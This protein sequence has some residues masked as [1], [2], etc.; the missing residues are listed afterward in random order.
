MNRREKV[1]EMEGVFKE[2]CKD[3]KENGFCNRDIALIFGMT[4]V[5]FCDHFDLDTNKLYLISIKARDELNEND[6][7]DDEDDE[8]Y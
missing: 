8:D 6:D 4:F 2:I 7:E 3:L 1:E 5:S